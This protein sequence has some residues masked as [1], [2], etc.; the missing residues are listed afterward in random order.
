MD[1]KELNNKMEATQVEVTAGFLDMDKVTATLFLFLKDET[2]KLLDVETMCNER[3]ITPGEMMHK[4]KARIRKD[5]NIQGIMFMAEA[6]MV[7]TKLE[8]G[9]S[10]EVKDVL[11]GN[12]KPSECDAK[13]EALLFSM[14]TR[15]GYTRM[16]KHIITRD[17]VGRG[18]LVIDTKPEELVNGKGNLVNIF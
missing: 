17:I 10:E 6:W 18:T 8:D 7:D 1:D 12:R 13:K 9:V 11:A 14:Q 16:Y 3:G 4:L 5:L 2:I 15:K